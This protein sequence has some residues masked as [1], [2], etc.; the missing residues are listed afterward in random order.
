MW[1]FGAYPLVCGAVCVLRGARACPERAGRPAV[2]ILTY[3]LNG[4]VNNLTG[5][6]CEVAGDATQEQSTNG[7]NQT[8]RIRHHSDVGGIGEKQV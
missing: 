2:A 6:Q 8:D 1:S 5:R 4:F 3:L 7:M